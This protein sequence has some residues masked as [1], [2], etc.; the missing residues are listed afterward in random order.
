L[1]GLDAITLFTQASCTLWCTVERVAEAAGCGAELKRV[2]ADR[3]EG[4]A[5]WGSGE[6]AFAL[7]SP[8]LSPPTP[9]GSGSG[10]APVAPLTLA[11]ALEGLDV[12]ACESGR[13]VGGTK[14]EEG[15][16]AARLGR[17]DE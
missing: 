8:P 12:A 14:E 1:G 3:E 15:V 13:E 17:V 4:R 9:Q 5:V 7:V 11:A 16:A 10:G 2:Q 6:P